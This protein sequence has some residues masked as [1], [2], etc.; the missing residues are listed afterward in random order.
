MKNLDLRLQ[1]LVTTL[2]KERINVMELGFTIENVTAKEKQLI[3]ESGMDYMILDCDGLCDISFDT[4][5]EYLEAMVLI[6]R[7]EKVKL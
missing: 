6:G 4:K 3:D 2:W 7:M 1:K 5:E